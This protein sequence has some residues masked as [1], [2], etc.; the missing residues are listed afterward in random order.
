LHSVVT[1]ELL[2]TP[3][4]PIGAEYNGRRVGVL[5]DAGIFSF[6]PNKQITAG[7]GGVV[8]TRNPEIPQF[9]KKVR[10]QGRDDP[11]KW[12]Q[13]S[14]LGYNYRISDI[15]CALGLEQ[16][17]RFYFLCCRTAKSPVVS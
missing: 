3:C 4:E 10:N 2:R 11:E 17:R 15:N 16:F 5:G 8:V 7:E 12:F 14:E 1:C 13:H 6:Y 9:V